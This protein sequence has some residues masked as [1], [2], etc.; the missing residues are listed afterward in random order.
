MLYFSSFFLRSFSQKCT[1]KHD[2]LPYCCP[3]N[4]I[5]H[6][7]ATVKIH[8]LKVRTLKD[9]THPL[10]LNIIHKRVRRRF[11]TGISVKEA[12]W[13][14]DRNQIINYPS[15]QKN[16]FL[17]R[18]HYLKT[19]LLDAEGI[20][21]KLESEGKPYT[22]DD[23]ITLLKGVDSSSFAE[24]TDKLIEELRKQGRSGNANSYKN[25]KSVFLNQINKKDI[26]FDE[27]NY[28]LLKKFET[29]LL[30]KDNPVSVNGI[31][32]YM[33]TIRAIYNRAIK[34][35]A[36]KKENYPFEEYKIK[37]TKTQKRALSKDEI[38]K[39]RDANLDGKPG[40]ERARDYFMFSF[41][42]MGM[43]FVDVAHLKVK[44]ITKGRLYYS[45]LKTSQLYNFELLP[46][47]LEIIKKYSDLKDKEAYIFPILNPEAE[48]PHRDYKT[49]MINN[50]TKL[51]KIN[52][53]LKL[54]INLTFYVA[55]H[56]WATIAKRTG[57][58]TAIISEG[59]GHTTEKTTQIYLDSF[60]NSV[61][62]EANKK[63]T[64]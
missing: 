56:S 16:L 60:E 3:L 61:L 58:S 59:L 31:S 29:N 28:S 55:R 15:K 7:M 48:D 44:N 23:I 32:F 38:K 49:S 45:R 41:Y 40:Q 8:L 5:L 39:I 21:L 4:L 53:K 17:K 62:D 10:Y 25:T 57:I 37:N 12:D 6:P 1:F 26:N 2:L 27:I 64:L 34:E 22:A 52:E 9:K 14:P 33:R 13:D 54:P 50:N 47:A 24:F 51:K 43:S 30:N 46:P 36:A 42:C 35:G 19:L 63:I 20:I 11:A 18:N